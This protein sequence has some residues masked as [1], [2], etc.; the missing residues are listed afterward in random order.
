MKNRC[1][2]KNATGYEYYGGRGIKV[3]DEW[4][5]YEPFREWAYVAGYDETAKRWD[6][7]IDRINVNGDY[8]P[9][10]CRFVDM[11][12]QNQNKRRSKA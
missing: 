5:K 3:C 10:N 8:E 1:S 9:S 6:C 2:C 7:T 4:Q 12:V 11:K